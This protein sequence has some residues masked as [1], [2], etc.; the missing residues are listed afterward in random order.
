M[1]KS[2]AVLLATGIIY[3]FSIPAFA[4]S[5]ATLE[6]GKQ[7]FDTWCGI[8]HGVPANPGD[9]VGT[10][11]LETRYQGVVPG[12]LEERTNLT[13][14]FIE[15]VVREG[16]GMMPFFRRVEVGDSDLDALSA[17]LTRNNPN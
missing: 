8:C 16:M 1:M 6:R 2:T 10:Q 4:Q 15:V 17:Y 9:M 3:L 13:P 7:V 5:A 12:L 14:A 11:R